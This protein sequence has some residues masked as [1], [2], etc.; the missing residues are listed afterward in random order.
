MLVLT[1]V[2]NESIMIGDRIEITIVDVKGDKVRFGIN[3]PPSVQVHRKEVYLAI[4]RATGEAS[5]APIPPAGRPGTEPEGERGADSGAD[6]A[7]FR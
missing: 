4:R 7:S 1:R 3:A 6:L 2:V 5:R